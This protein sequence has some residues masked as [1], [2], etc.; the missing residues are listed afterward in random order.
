[1]RGVL[2]LLQIS[3]AHWWAYDAQH[4]LPPFLRA[5]PGALGG[6]RLPAIRLPKAS[7]MVARAENN[8]NGGR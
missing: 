2:L 5:Q 7:R 8:G 1:M 3:Q 6:R 4:A